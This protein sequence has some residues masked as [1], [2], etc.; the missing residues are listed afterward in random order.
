MAATMIQPWP[1]KR[2]AS[3]PTLAEGRPSSAPWRQV[4]AAVIV[5]T[6]LLLAAGVYSGLVGGPAVR[7]VAEVTA[8]WSSA[9]LGLLGLATVVNGTV[10][11][12]REF[13]VDI[14][15]E[16]TALGLLTV[17]IAAVVAFPAA[18]A[19][20]KMVGAALGVVLLSALNLVRIA[21][22]FW[23]GANYREH[24]DVAHLLVW[25][26]AMVLA[27]I[28]LWLIWSGKADRRAYG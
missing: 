19:R 26:S 23:I 3:A 6:G 18:S 11:S 28:V 5:G 17:F 15:A 1:R 2:R 16:C 14:V 8:R 4:W 20:S 9:I 27:G 10:V 22:L 24:L 12:S 7:A 21:S 25:Q 13:A